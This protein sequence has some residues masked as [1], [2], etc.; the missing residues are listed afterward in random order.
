MLAHKPTRAPCA[1]THARLCAHVQTIT[2]VQTHMRATL[3]VCRTLTQ[4]VRVWSDARMR[5]WACVFV[6]LGVCV[7]VCVCDTAC[8]RACVRARARKCMRNCVRVCVH[9]HSH[10]HTRTHTR[11]RARGDGRMACAAMMNHKRLM[12]AAVMV[13][14]G[15][16]APRRGRRMGCGCGRKSC[17]GERRRRWPACRGCIQMDA[18]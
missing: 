9:R 13:E 7:C 1:H 3:R 5:A 2:C 8:V 11:A 6:G 12:A 10:T 18:E 4:C 14:G 17:E 15:I 16:A